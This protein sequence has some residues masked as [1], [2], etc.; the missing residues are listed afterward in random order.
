[1]NYVVCLQQKGGGLKDLPNFKILTHTKIS[2][3]FDKIRQEN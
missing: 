1:M 3:K 2:R